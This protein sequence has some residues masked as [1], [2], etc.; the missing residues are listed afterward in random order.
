MG[1][2]DNCEGT[3][4]KLQTQ[5][6][7]RDRKAKDF[8][9]EERN[10]LRE[11]TEEMPART[12]P[13]PSSLGPPRQA[14][15]RGAGV[16][17]GWA[18]RAGR[19]LG[20]A[21]RPYSD[22]RGCP[23]QLYNLLPQPGGRGRRTDRRMDRHTGAGRAGEAPAVMVS[24]R[25]GPT[26]T[27]LC[28]AKAPQGRF[29]G[30]VPGPRNPG[31]RPSSPRS[32]GV[33]PLAPPSQ[34]DPGVQAPAPCSLSPG[35]PGRPVSQGK[36]QPGFPDAGSERTSP[37]LEFGPLGKTRRLPASCQTQ[38]SRVRLRPARGQETFTAS[39]G[40]FPA[41]VLFSASQPLLIYN[42]DS[43]DA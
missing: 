33:S 39:L 25:H 35:S 1:L 43:S 28:A 31:P 9:M 27:S 30:W 41:L 19:S 40:L 2:R 29:Y 38:E 6:R 23:P 12:Q 10:C 8:L 24:P 26:D 21:R 5:R 14:A 37:V 16:P 3:H 32:P 20:K 7:W 34:G 11:R 13:S 17:A 18:S 4:R 36:A 15:G 42:D 22:L